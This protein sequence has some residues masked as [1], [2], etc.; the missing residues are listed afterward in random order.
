M[1]DYKEINKLSKK[2]AA[3]EYVKAGYQI[4]PQ[5]EDDPKP[6]ITKSE[7]LEEGLIG[8]FER[9]L[10]NVSEVENFWATRPGANIRI[11]APDLG[12][13]DVDTHKEN[14]F[15]NLPDLPETLMSNSKSGTGRHYWFK[16][17]KGSSR[18]KYYI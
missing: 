1:L 10:K 15:D 2:D 14:G 7:T 9:P 3:V 4:V 8:S 5:H 11:I 6:I 16:N 18:Y 17:P 13:I 12:I